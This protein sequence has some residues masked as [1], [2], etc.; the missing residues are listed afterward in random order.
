MKGPTHCDQCGEK[1]D[2]FFSKKRN[3][4][5]R[6]HKRKSWRHGVTMKDHDYCDKCLKEQIQKM[7]LLDHYRPWEDRQ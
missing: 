6:A 7:A 5:A 3:P 4:H 2:I 1:I